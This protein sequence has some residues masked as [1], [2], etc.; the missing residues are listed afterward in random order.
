[1]QPGALWQWGGG[2]RVHRWGL[3]GPLLPRACV[4]GK[5]LL[6]VRPAR[7]WRPD[8]VTRQSDQ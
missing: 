6:A 5:S 4:G 3:R 8:S 2:A 7:G 1:M